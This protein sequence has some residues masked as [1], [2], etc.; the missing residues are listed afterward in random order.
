MVKVSKLT[1]PEDA[2]FLESE[3]NWPGGQL[4]RVLVPVLDVIAVVVILGLW[5]DVAGLRRIRI[6]QCQVDDEMQVPTEI[7]GERAV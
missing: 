3:M 5:R 7:Q 4:L 6:M 2:I 1:V